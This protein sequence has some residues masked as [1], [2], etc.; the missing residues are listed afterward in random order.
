MFISSVKYFY[1]LLCLV[2][3][4]LASVVNWSQDEDSDDDVDMGGDA[5]TSVNVREHIWT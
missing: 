1:V 2:T 3:D 5:C 4:M